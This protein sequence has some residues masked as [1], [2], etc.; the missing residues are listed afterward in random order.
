MNVLSLD[1][2]VFFPCHKYK[3]VRLKGMDHNPDDLW[4]VVDALNIDYEPDGEKIFKVLD[5]I[6]D[7]SI[8]NKYLITEHEEILGILKDYKNVNLWNIDFHH[9]MGYR[10]DTCEPRAD[11]WVLHGKFNKIIGT[12]T[13]VRTELSE[14]LFEKPFKITEYNLLDEFEYPKFDKLIICVYPYYTPKKFWDMYKI[15]TKELEPNVC[16]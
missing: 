15:F 14:P 8:D 16:N 11:D 10:I 7:I 9:D 13:W 2:D 1:L 5:M 12:Y 6:G 3:C 4:K